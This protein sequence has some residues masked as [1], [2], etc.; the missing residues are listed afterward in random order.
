MSNKPNAREAILDTASRLFYCQGYHATGLNQIIKDSE[1]PK[2][3]LYYYFPEGK[4]ELALACIKRTSEHMSEDLRRY[5]ES[6]TTAGEA[7]STL[8]HRIARDAAA[9]GYEGL[10]PLSFWSAVEASGIS[11]RLRNACKSV[12]QEWQS[13]IRERLLKDGFPDEHASY[14]ASATVSLIEGAVLQALTIKEETP[15][16]AAAQAVLSVLNRNSV[17]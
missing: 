11:D 1:S 16:L 12:F 15:L 5:M 14:Q 17:S 10:V 2:G 8:L 7:I 13:V 6:G 3:S 9:T 4:E